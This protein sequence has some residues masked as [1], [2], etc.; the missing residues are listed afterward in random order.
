MTHGSAAQRRGALMKAPLLKLPKLPANYTIR[1][2]PPPHTHPQA[3]PVNPAV[4]LG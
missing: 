3:K 4:S 2:P 1:F